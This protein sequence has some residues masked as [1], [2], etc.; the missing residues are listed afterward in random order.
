MV[1]YMVVDGP[2]DGDD[3]EADDIGDELRDHAGDG[4]RQGS[5][6]ITFV[7]VGYFKVEDQQGDG[8]GKDAIAEGNQA[9]GADLAAFEI[10]R[11]SHM[12]KLRDSRWFDGG[13]GNPL[14]RLMLKRQKIGYFCIMFYRRKVIMGLLQMFGGR[15]E[16]I[17]LQKLLFM[18][19]IGQES[20]EYEFVP[21]HYG[22]YSF[23]VGADLK[24][25]VEKGLLAEDDTSYQKKDRKDYLGA[26]D[27]VDR[28]LVNQVYVRYSRLSAD[29]LMHHSYIHYPYYAI[30]SVTA[31]RLLTSEQLHLV[32][33]QR[34]SGHLQALFTIG[35]EGVSLEAYLN[36]LLQNDIKLLVDVRNNPISQKFGFSKTSLKRYCEALGIEYLHFPDVGIKSALRRE[37][38]SQ[39]DYNDLFEQYKV[40]TLMKTVSTQEKILDLIAEKERLAI[41]CFEADICQCHRK[42][43]AE[44]I[45]KLPGWA[46]ELKHI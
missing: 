14:G 4:F 3:Q 29:D 7:K 27:D 34:P 44:A 45:V 5:M 25:M 41:T 39:D 22:C 35:Y 19:C 31:P 46:Y 1:H 9:G 36:K 38:N 18:I 16:K 43:L 28:K 40:Q 6:D 15:L 12:V 11:G 21:Y 42:H 20:P 17:S 30:K 26:L 23:S 32:H 10:E 24:T 8:D 13:K 37:L 2:E 33:A